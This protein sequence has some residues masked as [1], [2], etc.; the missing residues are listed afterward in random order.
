MPGIRTG[1]VTYSFP[2]A[3]HAVKSLCSEELDRLA[4]LLH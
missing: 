4:V 1:L 3:C 2:S